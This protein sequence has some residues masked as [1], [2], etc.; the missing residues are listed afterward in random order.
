MW[1]GRS[2]ADREFNNE[3]ILLKLKWVSG[4]GRDDQAIGRAEL[5]VFHVYGY[6]KEGG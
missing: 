3:R 2:I 6:G 5:E 1:M 4:N